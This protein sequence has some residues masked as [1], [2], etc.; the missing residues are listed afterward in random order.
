MTEQTSS[1]PRRVAL[2]ASEPA[3]PG[4]RVDAI[5]LWL[6]LALALWA[7]LPFGSARPWAA[8]LL[9]VGIGGLIL[10]LGIADARRG[11]EPAA[12]LRLLRLPGALFALA[13]G[14]AIIQSLAI[15]PASWQHPLWPEAARLLPGQK[16]AGSIGIDRAGS[17]VAI[18]H[19]LT[20][21]G[22]FWLS[23]RL[24]RQPELTRR[25]VAGIAAIGAL[26]AGWGLIVYGA[27]NRSVLWFDKW[28]YSGDLTS[29][30]VNRN[31]FAT[32]VGLALVT[33]MALLI[34]T[35]LKRLDL[36]QDRRMILRSLGELLAGRAAWLVGSLAIVATALLL[37]HSRGGT[38]ATGIGIVA[39]LAIAF[40]APS[41][42][43]PWR[44]SF[45]VLLAA[46]GL[47]AILLSGAG[48]ADRLAET[49]WNLEG[50][51]EIYDLTLEAIGNTPILGTGL[52]T[53]RW[54]FMTY[55]PEDIPNTVE[56]AHDEY[57]EN[58]L[59]LGIPAALALFG[60]VLLLAVRC[61]RGAFLRRRDAILPCLGFAASALVGV[62]SLVDFSLHIPA[63]TMA[64]L[65]ILG[66]AVA[67]STPTRGRA[68]VI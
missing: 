60:S 14:W 4:D 58:M 29:T 2:L 8:G 44:F 46:G 30:F 59:E 31:S 11:G 53:F 49:N 25:L 22:M 32:F 50:R 51:H 67:Q 45:G 64:Y 54:I 36:R 55:R 39:L 5:C 3:K 1:A 41:L 34:D 26:Y 33:L 19:L 17:L 57:L 43:G 20:Y 7:P 35:I 47:A 52:G 13:I 28:A 56:L 12:P 23:F 18:L 6:L 42:R 68:D 10:T 38:A 48:T 66:A 37:T 40:L 65:L 9:A 27:G 61:A 21:A 24:C 15:V 16:V 63:V 62:H